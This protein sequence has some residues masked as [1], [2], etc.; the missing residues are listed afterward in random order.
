MFIASY[1]ASIGLTDRA[2]SL[3]RQLG[4]ADP[5]RPEPF[6]QGLALAK[7]TGDLT[8]IQWAVIGILGQ[9]WT[10]DDVKI[11]EDAYRLAKATYEKLLA[12]GK[13]TEAEALDA[14]VRK[15]M[16]RDCVV[17]VTWT[18]DADVDIAVEEPAG[19]ICS[20][21]QPRTTS[22][23]VHLGDVAATANNQSTKAFKEMYVCPQAFDGQYR[24][25][26]KNVWGKTTSRK[27]NVEVYTNYGS[28]KQLLTSSQIPLGEK[29]AAVLFEIKDGRRQDPLPEAQ[30]ANI[31]NVQNAMNRQILGQ[32]LAAM[33][34]SEAARNLAAMLASANDNGLFPFFRRGAVGYR[35]VIQNFP[36]GAGFQSTAVISADRRYVRVAPVPFFSQINEVNTF[37]FVTGEGDTQQQGGG[38]GGGIGFGGG[39]GGGIF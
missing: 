15:A 10:G 19:T 21:H 17:V 4:N 36:E 26:V 9:A 7:R 32:Q 16:R 3:C 33:D 22:G 6:L 38:G 2:L 18:G 27:V 20:A 23:G 8:T 5:T 25:L 34:D 35:P 1:M 11:A 31:V 30:V 14:G 28:E 24:L 29:N 39:G 12:D 13:K 37:N